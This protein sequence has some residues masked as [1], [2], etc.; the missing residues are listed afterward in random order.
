MNKIEFSDINKF[1]ASLGLIS[2]GLAFFLPWFINQNS[3][4]LTL[5]QEKIHDLTPNAQ[6]IIINHQENLLAINHLLPY[7]SIGLIILGLILL[8]YGIVKWKKRQIVLDKIQDEELKFKE[9]QNISSQEKR[10]QII[11]ELEKIESFDNEPKIKSNHEM[12]SDV[13]TY[14]QIEDTI[15]LQLTQTYKSTYIPS[16]NIRIGDFDYD[17]ILKSKD[18]SINKDKIIE[19]KFF[20]HQLTYELIK[21][22]VTKLVF[23]C[24][25]YEE[26]FKRRTTPILI[27]IYSGKEFDES[28]KQ[29]KKRLEAYGIELHKPLKVNFFDYTRVSEAKAADYLK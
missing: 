6:Q 10:E 5:E 15:F 19:I 7:I 28:I 22:A 23:S 27:V 17:I 11:N 9:T 24:N 26:S 1:L 2:I 12:Q 18:P 4:L 14:I 8:I 25:H 13:D 3:S 20:K 21:D 29:Y 16:H